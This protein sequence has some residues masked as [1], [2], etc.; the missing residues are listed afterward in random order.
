MKDELL[1][2]IES[3]SAEMDRLMSALKAKIL[4]LPDNPRISRLRGSCFT[5]LASNLGNNLSAEHHDFR[6]Q[7]RILVEMMEKAGP[8][9]A[10][11]VLTEAIETESLCPYGRKHLNLHPDVVEHLKGLVS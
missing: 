4:E 5:M 7:Y 10:L 9:S 1:K 8:W 6:E 3:H 2:E 11:K